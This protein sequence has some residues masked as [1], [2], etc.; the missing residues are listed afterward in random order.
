MQALPSSLSPD[1]RS[2]TT[3]L[4]RRFRSRCYSLRGDDL[5]QTVRLGVWLA[6]Q[7][8]AVTDQAVPFRAY[9]YGVVR[10]EL[11]RAIRASGCCA[12]EQPW[13]A[14]PPGDHGR[15]PS[16]YIAGDGPSAEDSLCSRERG[17]GTGML[18]TDGSPSPRAIRVATGSSQVDVAARAHVSLVTVRLYEAGS[19]TMWPEKKRALDA[20]YA[21][22]AAQLREKAAT[23]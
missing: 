16:T 17:I 19:P 1:L 23:P 22:L 8:W 3:D 2:V 15:A 5:R 18:T 7:R 4:C 13:D 6:A 11:R 14:A 21:E 10:H 20:V 9:A 12:R